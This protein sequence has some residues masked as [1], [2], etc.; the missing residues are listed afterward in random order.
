MN[1]W[2]IAWRNLMRRKMRTMLTI[3]S[4][5]IGVASTFAV[6]AAV[7]SAKKAFPL[8]MKE[9]FGRADYS[10][11]GT[12]AYFDEDVYE[13][14]SR[15]EG[16]QAVSYL[17]QSS[18]LVW[19]EEGVT[20]IQKRVDLKGFSRLDTGL[21]G[22]K[23]VEGDLSNDG[24]VITDRT[25]KVWKAE[26]GDRIAF[27]TDNGIKELNISAI[28]KYTA[29]L[30]GPSSWM[31]AKYHPWTVAVPLESLQEWYG[32]SGKVESI[33]VQAEKSAELDAIGQ[34]LDKLAR[35]SGEVYIQPTILDL[36]AQYK[37]ADTFFLALYIAGFLGIALSAFVIFNTLYVSMKE[38][39]NEFAAMKTIGYT[40]RQ[41]SNFVLFEVLL[42][43]V[44][45]TVL[46]LIIGFGLAILLKAVIFMVFSVHADVGMELW[47]GLVIS[48]LA[49]L[50]VP[51]LASLYP[52]RQAGKVSVV[53]V[54]K[55]N[56][57]EK[58]KG[59]KWRLPAGLLLIGSSFFIK[60]LLLV[61]PLLAGI[62]LVF[63]VLFQAFSFLLR[64]L[65]RAVFG[66][67]GEMAARNLNRSLG[68]TSMTAVI[69]SIGIAMVVLM[70]S[71]N[72]AFIQ[73]YERVIHAT[74]G[75]NLDIMFH[76]IEPT[77]L[78][79]MKQVDG[80]ADAVTYPLQAVVWTLGGNERLLP[81]Y[82]VGADWIDRFPLFDA[83]E[84]TQPSELIAK[85]QPDEI[86][87]DRAAASVW[88]GEVGESLTLDTI[89]GPKPFKVVAV[90]E[91]MKNSGYGAIMKNEHFREHI[92][93]KYERNALILKDESASPL[94]LRENLFDQ[95]GSRI[96]SMFGPEDWVSVVGATYTGSF[97]IVNFLIVLSILISGMG[98]ANTLLMN[99]MERIRELGM[100]RAVGVTRRQLIRMILL[101]GF[102]IG[103]T[104]TVIGCAF[105]VLLIYQTSTFLAINSLTYT[106]GVSWMII[107]AIALFGILV[108]LASSFAPASK[109]AKTPLS[110]ALRY[111]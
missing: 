95:F 71:L 8:Y 86:M 21:T 45:G 55:E 96:E 69:L 106:F 73:T 111:E 76:H 17:K 40:P 98:I 88:G 51:V 85:L 19:E 105:G 77:D 78:E 90:I 49:G 37:D 9:A 44:I 82:G 65:Y 57:A 39:R 48:S 46:G 4:I 15:I 81:V 38:R 2:Q 61:V 101:E 43:A 64:P 99:I 10:V 30:M 53:A 23:V 107:G 11:L 13:D 28:V 104:A 29:S 18:T 5:M 14:V 34:Q 70:S 80:V 91:T 58:R 3:L 62:A 31:M 36:D 27:A 110:E 1:L 100:M 109:A 87:L 60:H 59:G 16:A 12:E 79:E 97:S 84:G 68:R 66:F 54:L 47:K 74:Y 92:G 20:A 67:S 108:S 83:G 63:P 25:A 52:I 32:K 102:G 7:D 41:L 42:L 22:F 75:G 72:S 50:A 26:V 24:A 93:L 56:S 33:L 89:D 103:L 6:I 35:A 94:Q